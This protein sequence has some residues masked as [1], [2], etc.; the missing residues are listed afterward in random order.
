M[1]SM[2]LPLELLHK[3]GMDCVGSGITTRISS[4]AVQALISASS[5]PD[6]GT[7]LSYRIGM[8][9]GESPVVIECRGAVTGT[10]LHAS[11]QELI[12]VTLSIEAYH[13]VRP[14]PENQLHQSRAA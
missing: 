13:F 9:G 14:T 8:I 5:A 2:N 11:K 7:R 10:A 4:K 1:Y 3:N 12:Q 6:F